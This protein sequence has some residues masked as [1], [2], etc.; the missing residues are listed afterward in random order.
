MTEAHSY[1]PLP[2]G[3]VFHSACYDP[4]YDTVLYLGAFGA[5]KS[6]ALVQ[7]FADMAM[8]YPG[9][10]YLIVRKRFTDLRDTTLTTFKESVDERLYTY[11]KQENTATFINGSVILFRGLDKMK[12]VGS[13]EVAAVGI[14]EAYELTFDEFKMLK[15]R[16]R[17]KGTPREIAGKIIAS[18][19][20][21]DI[22]KNENGPEWLYVYFHL[23]PKENP[24]K[25]RGRFHVKANSLEN[26]YLPP[27]YV[28]NLQRDYPV[29]WVRRFIYGEWGT[30]PKG[31]AVFKGF[32]R[33]F[34]GGAWHVD[35][36]LKP[37]K[38]LPIVRGWDFGWHHPATVWCQLDP[39]RRLLIH[40]V[41]IGNNEYLREY[42][43]RVL[44]HSQ[45]E[46]FNGHAF[47][48]FEFVDHAG[49]QVK[50]SAEKT[51]V[52]ILEEDYKLRCQSRPAHVSE[53][54]EAIQKQM[55]LLIKGSPGIVIHPRCELIIAAMEGGYC[56]IRPT[57]G[58]QMTITPYKDGYYEHPM[59]ALRYVF[60]GLMRGGGLTAPQSS[61]NISIA[62]P[63]WSYNGGAT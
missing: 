3:R 60:N 58:N 7:Q 9:T 26:P 17:Q 42:A 52:Q 4:L 53:E 40:D 45:S 33:D 34:R 35:S 21:C 47:H 15:A 14:D 16:A 2:K 25:Y 30:V 37:I 10:R 36:Q 62:E 38:G 56:R 13:L 29:S 11:N 50:D 46:L 5:G 32:M 20:P 27:D 8:R 39:D 54:L 61:D 48:D 6:L 49:N 43:P 1:T 23:Q 18:S 24:S 41:L 22:G 51:S 55:N 12:K 31:D 28:P 19:N 44:A 59:D 57:D 63:G